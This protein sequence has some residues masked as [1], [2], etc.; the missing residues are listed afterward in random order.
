MRI[1]RSEN[2]NLPSQP[3]TSPKPTARSVNTAYV[4]LE[5]DIGVAAVADAAYRVGLPTDTPGGGPD[6]L[7][8][9]FVLGT[10]SPSGV[11]MASAYATFAQ[12]GQRVIP[13]TVKR[14]HK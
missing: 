6:S 4:E 12:R 5:A 2:G 13:T 10:A 11:D 9:T 3:L 8:L 1:P 14:Y 7:D